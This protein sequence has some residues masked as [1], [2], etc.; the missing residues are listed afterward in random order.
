[1]I[2]RGLIHGGARPPAG[3]YQVL[4]RNPRAFEFSHGWLARARAVRE[5]RQALRSAGSW[6]LLR[7]PAGLAALAASPAA[8]GGTVRYPTFLPLFSNTGSS[9]SAVMIPGDVAAE[10]WG[11][12]PAPP[13]SITTYYRE[14]SNGLLTVTGTVIPP[15]RVSRTDTFYAGGYPGGF[16]CQGL[17]PASQVPALIDEI[18]SHA[19]STVNFAQY[20]DTLTD[21][22]PAIVILDPQVGGECY[23][24][25][26]PA[27]NSI[28]AHRFSLTGWG[29]PAFQTNDSLNGKPVYVDDYII[30]G[31]EGGGAG[32]AVPGCTPG[33][34]TPIGT[35]THETGHLFDLPDLYDVSG[36][37]EGIGRWDL[38]SS[39]NEQKPWRPSHMSAWS[40][41]TLGWITEIPVT[42][43]QTDTAAPIETARTAYLVPLAGAPSEFF[44]LE[45]RQPIGSDSMM[46]GPGLMIYHLDT[47]LM[48]AR[49]FNNGNDVN[50]PRPH[51]L[52]VEEAAGDTGLYCTY[53]SPCNDR[54][55]AGD[56]F[57]GTSGN[58]TFGPGTRPAALTNTLG[59]A[60]VKIDSIQQLSPFGAVRFRV[61]FGAMTEVVASDTVAM[62]RVNAVATHAYRDI[63]AD[64]TSL[65]LAIDSVQL[66]ADARTQYLFQSWSD[67][68][69]RAH[70][71][72]A[73]SA[74]GT[75]TATV[76][77]R[78][79]V[80]LV[81]VGGGTVSATTPIDSANGTFL[82]E[83]SADTLRAVPGVGQ[84]FVGWTADTLTGSSL[85]ILRAVRPYRLVATFAGTTDIVRQ[86]LTGRSVL[87]GG[88]LA[89]LDYLGNNNRR[90]DLGDFVAWLD[91]NP[92]ALTSGAVTRV[93]R[94]P[95]PAPGG[96]R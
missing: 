36:A 18:L 62:V 27:V 28:W 96:P 89:S 46:Y 5:R 76:G 45:N 72:T 9:D 84:A 40:L 74:G 47:A 61:T 25:Y 55:D 52:A 39:G 44:L 42:S 66:S 63:L 48:A 75:F 91:R 26:P 54:G 90:F 2:R 24:L 82:A 12:T 22:V 20:A 78:Y 94:F 23:Q 65:A 19:D 10:F 81:T 1:M 3:F 30:Q 15:I 51:A 71:V 7:V 93:S 32:S 69:P 56:P 49:G 29:Y 53:P 34:L 50:A 14:I 17:C 59:F 41:A 8:V 86:L 77:R 57:P 31:G 85:V 67:G 60:G 88:Q 33:L 79:L 16:P 35:V 87:T 92:G 37:T 43:S 21:T 73:S 58:A 83:G 4:A 11:T 80:N 68:Q 38:M 13:Y 6:Q 70:T 95:A 64:G